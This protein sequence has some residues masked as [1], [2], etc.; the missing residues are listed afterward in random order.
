MFGRILLSLIGIG[1]GCLI[2]I[3]REWLLN[4]LGRPAW[5]EKYMGSFGGAR[6]F[7]VLLGI[8]I[9]AL[10]TLYMT[11]GLGPIVAGLLGRFFGGGVQ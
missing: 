10:S 6:L 7:Y 11:G 8:I 3:Y 1:V 2:A 4:N 9:V 5:A